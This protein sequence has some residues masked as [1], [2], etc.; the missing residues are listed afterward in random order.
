MSL[1]T[2]F[3]AASPDFEKPPDQSFLLLSPLEPHMAIQAED[4][5]GTGLTLRPLDEKNPKQYFVLRP[6]I[7][8]GL[9]RGVALVNLGF[10][11]AGSNLWYAVNYAGNDKPLVMKQYDRES[12]PSNAWV[13]HFADDHGV[14]GIR[15]SRESDGSQSWNDQH[16]PKGAHR[17]ISYDDK[18]DNSIW[19]VRF[20]DVAAPS[21]LVAAATI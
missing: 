10:A 11:K 13:I 21:E 17:I 20:A 1:E 16:N 8:N 3:T 14:I 18:K 15:I 5:P 19:R 4:A 2:S 9:A 7:D 6:A 12:T